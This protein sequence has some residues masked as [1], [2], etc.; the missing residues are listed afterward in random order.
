MF[1]ESSFLTVSKLRVS[2]H[3]LPFFSFLDKLFFESIEKSGF[4]FF[5]YIVLLQKYYI[6]IFIFKK[7]FFKISN[8]LFLFFIL[9]F[10]LFLLFLKSFCCFS[11]YCFLHFF[12][13]FFIFL[14]N[15]FFIFNIFALT[16]S[17]YVFICFYRTNLASLDLSLP[18]SIFCI[19]LWSSKKRIR[20]VA[21]KNRIAIFLCNCFIE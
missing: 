8:F 21:T 13:L 6:F 19:D 17:I 14:E 12:I 10:S 18:F 20:F 15:D 1:L 5:Y 2:L 9:N 7:S 4:L 16:Y 3:F 11:F